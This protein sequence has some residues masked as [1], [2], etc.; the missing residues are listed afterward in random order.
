MS[1][2]F[3]RLVDAASPPL[4][5]TKDTDF[6]CEV[7]GGMR[8]ITR[9][10]ARHGFPIISREPIVLHP[11]V[12]SRGRKE[13]NKARNRRSGLPLPRPGTHSRR[14]RTSPPVARKS[15]S[16]KGLS[17]GLCFHTAARPAPRHHPPRS[18]SRRRRPTSCQRRTLVP[19]QRN[20]QGCAFSRRRHNAQPQSV[21]QG[22]YCGQPPRRPPRHARTPPRHGTGHRR[23]RPDRRGQA[24][25]PRVSR[26]QQ[27]LQRR[28]HRAARQWRPHIRQP[29]PK[30]THHR[31]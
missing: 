25:T 19:A 17:D 7:H 3:S 22:N 26:T 31:R 1:A 2:A 11:P 13:T 30:R 27:P 8:D 28:H 10:T 5:S 6:I 16:P 29:F 23:Y 12:Q 14:C 9:R 18:L 20:P 15:P 4:H 21:H 24:A